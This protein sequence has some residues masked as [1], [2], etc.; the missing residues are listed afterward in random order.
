MR[1]ICYQEYETSCESWKKH[2]TGND[3]Q[4]LISLDLDLENDSCYD[5]S[6]SYLSFEIRF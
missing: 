3:C 4:F 6:L 2:F 1:T 5:N